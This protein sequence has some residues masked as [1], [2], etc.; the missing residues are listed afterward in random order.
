MGLP[1]G[2]IELREIDAD[3]KHYLAEPFL[4]FSKPAFRAKRL[5]GFETGKFKLKREHEGWLVEVAHA[6]PNNRSFVI[7]MVGY[8]SKL[9]FRGQN[10][11]QSDVSNVTL[12]FARAKFP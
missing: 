2:W 11:A 12:S 1:E 8:A 6:I 3:Q 7:Y 4:K 9:G 5:I 10:A